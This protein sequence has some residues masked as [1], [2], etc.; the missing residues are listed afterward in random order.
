MPSSLFFF[1]L[2]STEMLMVEGNACERRS[3]HGQ[4]FVETLDTVTASAGSGRVHNME[5]IT[6]NFQDL[7]ASVTSHVDQA[8][9]TKVILK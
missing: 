3:K 2:V 8:S 4:G 5:L 9:T 1:L 7:L 6:P